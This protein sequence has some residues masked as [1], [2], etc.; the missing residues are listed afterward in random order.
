M[1]LR[2]FLSIF[3]FSTLSIFSQDESEPKISYSLKYDSVHD[4]YIM[5]GIELSSGLKFENE[6]KTFGEG[7]NGFGFDLYSVP[8]NSTLFVSDDGYSLSKIELQLDLIESPYSKPQKIVVMEV[9]TF[10]GPDWVSID[11]KYQCTARRKE[12]LLENIRIDFSERPTFSVHNSKLNC[13]Q[14][15][16]KQLD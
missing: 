15:S 9:L 5:L 1:F 11:K 12:V 14:L 2:I 7:G 8:L 6:Y 10:E 3:V 13:G 16:F 4:D